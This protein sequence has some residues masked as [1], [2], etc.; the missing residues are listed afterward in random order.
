MT[1]S[2]RDKVVIVTGG[3]SGIGKE[4][5]L[6]FSR[7]HA[8]VC[9]A[10]VDEKSGR[11]TAKQAEE[12]GYE[13]AFIKTD[14]SNRRDVMRLIDS[15]ERDLS[16][17]DAVVNNAGINI[18]KKITELEEEEWDRLMSINLKS[19]FLTAKY[20]L[21]GMIERKSGCFVNI[22][23]VSGLAADYGFSVYNAAK[24]GM[25]NLTRN[26]AI[27]Y[28]IHGIRANIVCPG[29]ISTPLLEEAF[30]DNTRVDLRKSFNDAN[31]MGRIG[32]T[33]EVAAAV[34]FLASDAASFINGEVLNVDGG[35]TSH[36]G[37]PRFN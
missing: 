33:R 28:G 5:A 30:N 7:Y 29:A 25:V 1:E 10:D 17:I 6:T 24:A 27:N 32:T 36:T 14:V 26:I 13:I 12:A 4:I 3:A 19:V 22:G 15:V 18:L 11:D 8:R 35:I 37:Q 21:P 31:P 20:A 23:S 16:R 9:I 2:I 34:V